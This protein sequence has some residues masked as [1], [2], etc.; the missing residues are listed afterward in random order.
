MTVRRIAEDVIALEGDCPIEDAQVLLEYFLEKP[1]GRVDW[2]RCASTHTAV[3]QIL[4]VS[5]A[6][7]MSSP[8]GVFLKDHIFPALSRVAD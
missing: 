6:V 8:A 1:D 7:L 3:I 2:A 5:R 4:M